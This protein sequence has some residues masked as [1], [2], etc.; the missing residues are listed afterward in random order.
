M[1]GKLSRTEDKGAMS[2]SYGNYAGGRNAI[3]KI[4]L[5]NPQI[6]LQLT[7]AFPHFSVPL[8]T[9]KQAAP[10]Y[11]TGILDASLNII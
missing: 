4:K 3:H 11:T 5:I 9:S 2:P 8:L 7:H 6:M 10:Q 1:T